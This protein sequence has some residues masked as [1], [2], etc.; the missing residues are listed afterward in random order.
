MLEVT[1]AKY[2]GEHRVRIAFNNGEEGIVDL[3]GALWG[4]M[5]EPL[6][7]PAAFQHF[8]LSSVLH[9]LY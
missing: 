7:D 8:E 1:T 5:F 6:K 9:T 4:A 3:A 2:L